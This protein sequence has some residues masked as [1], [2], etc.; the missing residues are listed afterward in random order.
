[1]I[2]E[3]EMTGWASAASSQQI[4]CRRVLLSNHFSSFVVASSA[5]QVEKE[6]TELA[7]ATRRKEMQGQ[8]AVWIDH[9]QQ[10]H[11]AEHRQ[12]QTGGPN[13]RLPGVGDLWVSKI[14]YLKLI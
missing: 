2:L 4:R 7:S 12:D 10:S 8:A 13:W 6:R 9:A 14:L 11:Q 3:K 5:V 1:M